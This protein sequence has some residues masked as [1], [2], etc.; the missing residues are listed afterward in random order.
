MI[1]IVI[2]RKGFPL[3]KSLLFEYG[4]FL[5][6]PY[7][8]HAVDISVSFHK[9]CFL[10]LPKKSVGMYLCSSEMTVYRTALQPKR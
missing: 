9:T 7:L 3:V 8:R 2:A 5:L 6:V 10:A 1:V 4:L